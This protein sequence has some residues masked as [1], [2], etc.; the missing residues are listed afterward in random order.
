MKQR[1]Y[2]LT[3]TQKIENLPRRQFYFSKNFCFR[4]SSN[5]WSSQ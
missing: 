1:I 4:R 2:T 5:K 3:K